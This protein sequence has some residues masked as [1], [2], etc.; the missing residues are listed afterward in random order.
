LNILV[1]GA[2][3]FVGKAVLAQ[4]AANPGGGL[5]AA[6]R[7]PLQMPAAVESVV[8]G[9]LA[10]STDWTPAL[11]GIDVVV[12]AAA[13]VHVMKETAADP[14]AEFRRVNVV[15]T[16]A[17]AKQAADAGVRRLVFVSSVKVNGEETTP[18]KPFTVLDAPKP[19]DAYGISKL[20]AELGLQQIGA[21]CGM[22]IVVVRPSLV[23]GPE[24]R[25][26]LLTLLQWI[27]RGL[28]LPLG[29][30]DNQ[31]SFV[32][33]DNLVSL[34]RVC[35]THRAAANQV[36]L[37]ADG[38]D[39]STTELIRRLARGMNRRARLFSVPAGAFHS[40]ASLFGATAMSQRLCG[41][42][43]VDNS[44]AR[45]LLDWSTVVSV[46]DALASTARHFARTARP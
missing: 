23:Y 37:A 24:V 5:R 13:R 1:T 30:I 28:P 12:H 8:V 26:N 34:I 3:G 11:A 41:W 17:L 2:S 22:E 27:R 29:G 44:H 25:G 18:G 19:V 4:L 36:F 46:D 39:L 45:E 32:A 10:T 38:E 14:L 42:L 6:V 15:G 40:M 33:L 7:R 43:Q 21:A 16:L 9:D 31:R 35:V 20:E